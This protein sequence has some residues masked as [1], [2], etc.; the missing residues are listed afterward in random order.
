MP[1]KTKTPKRF[2]PSRLVANRSRFAIFVMS[3]AAIGVWVLFFAHAAPVAGIY[4][5]VEKDQ[6]NL[7]NNERGSHGLN[8]LSHIDCLHTIAENWS[9]SMA[10]SATLAHNP[11][12]ASQVSAS[13]GNQWHAIGENVGVSS[14]SQKMFNGFMASC[15]HRANIDSQT[16]DHADPCNT[17]GAYGSFPYTVVGVGAYYNSSGTLYVTQVYGYCPGC[18]GTW[19]TAANVPADPVQAVAASSAPASAPGNNSPIKI[20][21]I[22]GDK[23]ADIFQFVSDHVYA[24][25]ANNNNIGYTYTGVRS[26]NGFGLPQQIRMGDFDGDGRADIIR[27][28]D[29]SS[30]EVWLSS[31]TDF[32]YKAKL[33]PGSFDTVLAQQVN[34]GDFDGDGK[35]DLLQFTGDSTGS[36]YW[37]KSDGSNFIAQGKLLNGAYDLTRVRMGDMDGDGKADIFYMNG[38]NKGGAYV[39]HSEGGTSVKWM[40]RVATGLGELIEGNLIADFNGD[41]KVDLFQVTGNYEQAVYFW[42][43]NTTGGYNYNDKLLTQGG[44][45]AQVRVADINGD[46]KADLIKFTGDPKNG[47]GV[48]WLSA[49]TSVNYIGRIGTGFG[50]P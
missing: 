36:V 3:F 29:K 15:A 25:M 37:W 26:A 14:T 7:I 40:G 1:K 6:V 45:P 44:T 24:W 38:D 19:A 46:G 12:L 4:G 35:I 23:R 48:A 13:C 50:S 30:V 21:D 39:W 31:G 42:T 41:K 2:T 11:N 17:L 47:E 8:G 32:A 16:D 9:V 34:V 33:Y 18:G 28:N 20:A 43:A 27:I 10:N 5:S 49:G 22:N